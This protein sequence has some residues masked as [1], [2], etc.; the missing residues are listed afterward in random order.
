M[1]PQR[2][3]ASRS[4]RLR[5][6]VLVVSALALSCSIEALGQC[7][8][9]EPVSGFSQESIGGEVTGSTRVAGDLVEV[10]SSSRGYGRSVDS[11]LGLLQ[12]CSDEFDLSADV[13]RIEGLGQA[14]VEARLFRGT[15]SDPAQ[16]VVRISVEEDVTGVGFV[17]V[18]SLREARN[19][20]LELEGEAVPTTL[21]V[22]VG[23]ARRGDRISAYF[24]EGGERVEHLVVDVKP[25]SSLDARMYRVGM[26]HGSDRSGQPQPRMG[27]AFFR[28]PILERQQSIRPPQ[29][30]SAV[31]NYQAT[32]D[33]AA[34]VTVRGVGLADVL[35]VTV[36]GMGA[37]IL[38]RGETRVT[39]EVP[40]TGE[41]LRG[42]IVVRTPGGTSVIPN[43]FFSFG[44]SFIRC[45]C[46]G[47]GEVDISDMVS[48][49]S[50]Q[51][52]SGPPCR[53]EE[54]GDCNDD[55][56]R[57]ISDPISGLTFLFVDSHTAPPAPF[58]DPGV[59]PAAPMC[60]LDEALPRVTGISQ[61]RIAE[62][63]VFSIIGSGFTEATQVVVP[64]ARVEVLERSSDRL[65][66]RAGVVTAR[67]PVSIGLISDFQ[68]PAQLP[69]RPRFCSSTAMGPLTKLEEPVELVPSEV[70]VV[71]VSSQAD[72]R[73]PIIL[74]IDR[75]RFDPTR[76]LEVIAC[77]ESDPI[78][79]LSPGA[80][81]TSFQMMPD[82]TFEDSVVRLAEHLRLELAAGGHLGEI[83]VLP[84]KETGQIIIMRTEAFPLSAALTAHVSLY[85]G[86]IG[87]CGPDQTHPIDDERAHGWC[88][89]GELV[90][91][92]GG[93]PG[94]EWYIP[95]SHV[96][97]ISSDLGG[98][99]HPS[100]RSPHDK[101]ILFNWEAYCH[102][103]KHRLWNLCALERLVDL[104]R[105]EIPDFPVG[106]WV[107][108]TL[109]RSDAEIP[110]GVDRSK[111]YSYV[112]SGDGQTY[113][114]TAIH[115]ITKD[116][117]RWFWYD[118]YPPVQVLEGEKGEF[119]RGV[120]GCGGTDVDAPAWVPDTIWAN[121]YLCTNV[122]RTQPVSTS[123]VGGVG[124]TATENSAWCGNFEFATECPDVV[125]AANLEPADD[126]FSGDDTC[127]RCHEANSLA[128]V[129]G[130]T[131][132]VDFLHSLKSA[133]PHPYPC[134][135]TAGAVTYA[136]H[137]EPIINNNCSCHSAWM[138]YS[139][140]VNA[141]SSYVPSMDRIEP[142]DP[143]QSYLWH[144]IHNTHLG[145][146]GEGCAMPYDCSLTPVPLAAW[147]INA[148]E[149]WILDGAPY[150]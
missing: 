25:N 102:V 26:V 10:C 42:D 136:T 104:G 89:F 54:A 7:F 29:L 1:R 138:E 117:D 135:G 93:L 76:P 58:P 103:R 122:T 62:G 95:L 77:T 71:G 9:R 15:G 148:I 107:T 116:I 2:N 27:A 61:G 124:P 140:L 48:M 88:R 30:S 23:V 24:I 21:P 119:V 113:Y 137:I 34:V 73:A 46:S 149:Q 40:P 59:D 147:E 127:L 70:P 38:E 150:D 91:P 14:G 83:C 44:K 65:T 11:L 129:G 133:V 43:A 87:R 139:T 33:Q 8:Q 105:T 19:G 111:L 57:D 60:G 51:F 143:G 53:C 92:C 131:I 85:L 128:S 4:P 31:E 74:Q 118:M 6:T 28:D 125:D 52:L 90:E 145:V 82:K 115:H 101:E 20:P 121:Y 99:P 80:R 120:G 144:K 66:L 126:C 142:N 141:P 110:H 69:C 56:E 67:G 123:G 64:G 68:L 134:G 96:K 84:D 81:A 55:D 45:D 100:N 22:R 78:A 132:A 112:Y 39:V 32:L 49:L 75:E 5:T 98:L 79:N 108:K 47:D 41:P 16:A 63:D 146:G 3:V 36:A 109:W 72:P 12:D 130:S 97:S 94:F 114:L 35:E 37:K 18:S 106:A 50:H 86:T 13:V 17:I